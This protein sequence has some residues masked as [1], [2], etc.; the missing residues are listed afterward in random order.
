MKRKVKAQG[1]RRLEA[2]ELRKLLPAFG[3]QSLAR[4]LGILNDSSLR[5]KIPVADVEDIIGSERKPVEELMVDLLPVAQ[6]YSQSP[7]SHFKVGAVVLGK[8]GSLYL[9]TNI[10]VPGQMLG[11]SVHG[12]QCALSNA[13]MHD[14][15][16]IT[17][18]AVTAAPCGH[19]RQFLNELANSAD[20]KILVKGSAPTTLAKL[21]PESFGPNNLGVKERLF[22]GKKADLKLTTPAT[23]ALS[24][25]ASRAAGKSY[26]PYT[27]ALSGVAI[28]SSTKVVYQGSYIENVAYNPSLSPLQAALVGMIMAGETPG[29]ISAVTLVELENAPISQ[30]SAAQAVLDSLAPRVKVRR[31]TARLK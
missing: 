20:L 6:L 24:S 21:L 2:K 5:G 28:M 3:A 23:D 17:S 18:L 14:E 16:G 27:S 11:F 31:V 19:C 15:R 1:N 4:L 30:K 8:S 7:I 25:A 29:N 26:A 13:I 22:S 9:G 10:E 12:E